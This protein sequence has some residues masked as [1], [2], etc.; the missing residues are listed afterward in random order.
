MNMTYLRI[1]N[2]THQS[3]TTLSSEEYAAITTRAKSLEDEMRRFFAS[4]YRREGYTAAEVHAAFNSCLLTSIR[5]SLTNLFN[6]G[7]L[8]KDEKE[9]RP[10]PHGVALCVYKLKVKVGGQL[11][12]L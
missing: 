5:R 9:K 1:N 7:Y 2:P 6:E 4:N 3:G 8:V 12:L 11:E 10:G